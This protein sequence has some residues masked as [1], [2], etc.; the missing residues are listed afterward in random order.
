MANAQGACAQPYAH[1]TCLCTSQ[2]ETSIEGHFW[3]GPGTLDQS[4]IYGSIF[5]A[6]V[7]FFKQK[8]NKQTMNPIMHR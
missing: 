7:S 8:T 5:T 1:A 6:F 3:G 2:F 4:R